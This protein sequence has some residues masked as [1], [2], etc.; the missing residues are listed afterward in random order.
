M[1]TTISKM[2]T[3]ALIHGS[4]AMWQRLSRLVG[5]VVTKF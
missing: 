5:I 3:T 2:Q 4:Q 1:N